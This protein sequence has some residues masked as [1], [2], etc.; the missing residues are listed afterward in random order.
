MDASDFDAKIGR[1]EE[2]MEN[3]RQQM[4]KTCGEF[5]IATNEYIAIEFKEMVERGVISNPDIAKRHG[6][7]TL[8]RLK[9]ECKELI[10][11]VPDL[12][13]LYLNK[14]ENWGHRGKIPEKNDLRFE[15]YAMYSNA[16]LRGAFEEGIRLILG[17]VGTLLVKYGF[18]EA[19]SR[20]HA[21]KWTRIPGSNQIKYGIGFQWSEKM[22]EVLKVYSPQYN[23]LIKLDDKVKKLEKEKAQAQAKNLWD[24]V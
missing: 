8:R 9:S 22:T 20:L 10:S 21:Y 6:V 24:Q 18:E 1:L 7:D 11:S 4:E 15:R 12:V 14:D 5:L 3:L 19:D 23:E 2:E 13:N 16:P 17:Y